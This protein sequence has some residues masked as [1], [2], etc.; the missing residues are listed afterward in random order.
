VPLIAA[1]MY[2]VVRT[3]G[4]LRT[5]GAQL[6]NAVQAIDP[7]VA[8]SSLQPMNDLLS[9]SLSTWRANVQL[10]ET[11][12]YVA[13]LLCAIGVYAITTFSVAMRRRELAI[14]TAFGASR[15]D[16]IAVVLRQEIKPVAAG[17]VLGLC[18][19]L[20]TAPQLGSLLF[21]TSPTDVT[22]YVVVAGSMLALGVLA[23]YVPTR[24][25]SASDPVAILQA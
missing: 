6:Q 10:L 24:R 11:F 20:A 18:A 4:D 17:I 8:T 23:C 22:I 25:A 12:G 5:V 19:A 15:R 2:W 21:D 16:L 9:S 1:R 14:R 7:D 3:A 13:A